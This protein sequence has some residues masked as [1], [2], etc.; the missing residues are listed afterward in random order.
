[1]FWLW[2]TD[3]MLK[4]N[5]ENPIPSPGDCLRFENLIVLLRE[6]MLRILLRRAGLFIRAASHVVQ[7]I[8]FL[9]YDRQE[10]WDTTAAVRELLNE[11]GVRELLRGD[12]PDR[13]RRM[14]DQVLPYLKGRSVLDFGCGN[15]EV[16]VA[17]HRDLYEVTFY[18]LVDYRCRAARAL[19]FVLPGQGSPP[20]S[21]LL[22]NVL[23]HAEDPLAALRNAAERHAGRIVMIESVFGVTPQE[24]PAGERQRLIGENPSV[25]VWLSFTPEIQFAYNAF[26]DWFFA[27][28]IN[29]MPRTPCNYQRADEWRAHFAALGYTE[30]QRR[31]LGIDQP[32]VPEFHLLTAYDRD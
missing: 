29:E 19:P 31:W 1:M 13:S 4:N 26:W 6:Q 25:A 10:P 2:L 30:V 14:A 8:F 32:L 7:E 3:T 17:L 16:G 22:L 21:L 18:D 28:V 12:L 27:Q 5:F 20:A 11:H 15:G 9:I 24:I 23:H